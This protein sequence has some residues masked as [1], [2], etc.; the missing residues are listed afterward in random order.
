MN[1]ELPP[2]SSVVALL[3]MQE[4]ILF[5]CDL[6]AEHGVY[7]VNVPV[8]WTG[9]F[10]IDRARAAL[11]RALGRHDAFRIRIAPGHSNPEAGPWGQSLVL[12]PAQHQVTRHPTSGPIDPTSQLPI[13]AS[14]LS[15][16]GHDAQIMITFHHV[17]ADQTSILILIEDFIAF[18]FNDTPAPAGD[19]GAAVRGLIKRHSACPHIEFPSGVS[20]IMT[21][22]PPPDSNRAA[23]VPS[24]VRSTSVLDQPTWRAISATA[25]SHGLSPHLVVVA[26]YAAVLARWG[27]SRHI[28]IGI[29][30]SLRDALAEPRTAGC[31]MTVR[32]LPI[33]V[34]P[35]RSLLD[36]AKTAADAFA[37][38]LDGRWSP[39]L[40]QTADH[41]PKGVVDRNPLFDTILSWTEQTD[42]QRND[43]RV[44]V[45]TPL[46]YP[47]RL[48]FSILADVTGDGLSLAIDWDP[49]KLTEQT[50]SSLLV[51]LEAYLRSTAATPPRPVVAVAV[52][53]RPPRHAAASAAPDI[54]DDIAARFTAA[55][56][57]CAVMEA[58][59]E[60]H[61][62][63]ALQTASARVARWAADLPRS[64][65]IGLA[66]PR[67]FAMVA[68]LIGL[69]RAGRTVAL[70][71]PDDPGGIALAARS[72]DLTCILTGES[73]RLADIRTVAIAD[74][75][76]RGPA[77][78]TIERPHI[79]DRDAAILVFT[80][81]TSGLPKPVLLSRGALSSHAAWARDHFQITQQDRVLQFCSVAFDAM[82]EEIL[83]TLAAGAML[84]LRDDMS[85]ASGAAFA[86]YCDTRR[87]TVVDIPTGFF[88][89][90]IAEMAASAPALPPALLSPGLLPPSL[91]LVVIGGEPYAQAALTAW[92]RLTAGCADHPALLTTYGP[93]ETTIV[94]AAG[95]PTASALFPLLGDARPDCS[96]YVLDHWLEPCPDGVVGE[97]FVGGRA[98]AA[99]YLS[100]ATATA[101]KFIPDP[102]AH[103]PGA[104]MYRTGDMVVRSANGTLRYIGRSDRQIKLRGVRIEPALIETVLSAA[105]DGR[106]V[107][108]V[109]LPSSEAGPQRIVAFIQPASGTNEASALA[110]ARAGLPSMA[111]PA[112]IVFRDLP[113]TRRGKIDRAALQRTA[114]QR[115]NPASI[116]AQATSVNPYLDLVTRCIGQGALS[117][118]DD[119]FAVGGNS[120][121]VLRLI[122]LARDQLGALVDVR[123]VFRA[124]TIGAIAALL[125][126]APRAAPISAAPLK[127]DSRKLSD[128]EIA[129]YLDDEVTRGPSPYILEET[130]TFESRLDEVQLRRA[131][132]TMLAR[133]P[134]L[135]STV[136]MRHGE[137]WWETASL[138]RAI[139]MVLSPER[140]PA[141]TGDGVWVGL[142]IRVDQT[143]RG[144]RIDVVAHH[145][146]LDGAGL[147]R[148]MTELSQLYGSAASASTQHAEERL[149]PASPVDDKL[150]EAWRIRLSGLE[151]LVRLEP[152]REAE[153]ADNSAAISA[154]HSTGL[155]LEQLCGIELAARGPNI[156]LMAIVAAWL[157]RMT[158]S[159]E[160]L[161]FLAS[162][163]DADRNGLRVAT[164]VLPLRS[165]LRPRETFTT[166]AD[167]AADELTW[168]L[169]HR[170]VGLRSTIALLRDQLG[171]HTRMPLLFDVDDRR[172][173][174]ELDFAGIRARRA[175]HDPQTVRADVEITAV[176]NP[177]GSVAFRI[178]ARSA[179][180]TI[181][182]AQAWVRSLCCFARRIAETP[183]LPVGATALIDADDGEAAVRQGADPAIDAPV[184]SQLMDALVLQPDDARIVD[185]HSSWSGRRALAFAATI[186]RRLLALGLGPGAPVYCEMPRSIQY[187]SALLAIWSIGAIPV[188]VNPEHPIARRRSM[189]SRLP[190]AATLA[191][192]HHIVDGVVLHLDQ[193]TIAAEDD[194]IAS[195]AS[196]PAGETA[197]VAFTSGSTGEPKP[198]A[199]TWSGLGHLLSW[200]RR[201]VPM[202]S[203]HSFLHTSAPG[204]DIAVWEMLHPLISGAQLVVAES[205]G[206]GDV[207][208]TVALAERFHCTH[209]HFVP[210]V[211]EAFLDALRPDEGQALELV[212]CGGDAT[213]GS[214]HRRLLEQRRLPMQHCYGPTEATIFSLSWRG[215][216]PSPWLERLP[217]GDPIDGAG[218]AVVD[219]AGAP[220]VRGVFGELAVFGGALA[221]GYLG[222]ATETAARFR[223]LAAG[224]GP[225][226]S[227]TYLTG[228]RVRMLPGGAIEYRGRNDRQIKISGIRVE[229]SEVEAALARA[230]GVT[231]AV[232]IHQRVSGRDRLIAYVVAPG[233]VAED[234]ATI[235]RTVRDAARSRLPAAVVPH[236]VIVLDALPLNLNGKVD[237]SALPEPVIDQE[238][239][240]ER[241]D[242]ATQVLLIALWQRVLGRTS[243]GLDDDFF[244][245]GGDSMTAIRLVAMAR[246]QDLQIRLADVFRNPTVRRLAGSLKTASVPLHSDHR[247]ALGEAARHWL[248]RQ[249]R[250][251]G[252]GIQ[253]MLIRAERGLDA[254]R[255]GRAW[256]EV[257]RR[258]H[259]LSL[260]VV[261]DGDEWS[262]SFAEPWA[263]GRIP[264]AD[265]ADAA[266]SLAIGAVAPST[267]VMAA[268]R[269]VAGQPDLVALA[270]HHLAADWQS[271]STIL[272]DMWEA[273]QN[274]RS[275]GDSTSPAARQWPGE[276]VRISDVGD[277]K[278]SSASARSDLPRRIVRRT[279]SEE[280]AKS[281]VSARERRTALLLASATE[282]VGAVL[283]E[284]PVAIALEVDGRP[285]GDD[286]QRSRSETVGWFARYRQLRVAPSGSA[287]RDWLAAA[288]SALT[289]DAADQTAANC[290]C[291]LNIVPESPPL[292]PAFTAVTLRHFDLEP[293]HPIAIEVELANREDNENAISIIVDCDDQSPAG[294]AEALADAMLASLARLARLERRAR[295]TPLQAAMVAANLRRPDDRFYH[296]QII[297]EIEGNVDLPALR[298]A[299]TWAAQIHDAFRGRF[300]IHCPDGPELIVDPQ[301]RTPWRVVT[302]EAVA[303]ACRAALDD[304]LAEPFDLERGPLSRN[305][306]ATGRDGTRLIW[307]H[308]HSMFDGWSL[309]LV[310]QTVARVYHALRSGAPVRIR[311]PSLLAFNA[312]WDARDLDSSVTFWVERL[313]AAP[314]PRPLV[315][316]APAS[317][318]PGNGRACERLSLNLDMTQ[319]LIAAGNANNATL[320]EM[321]LAAWSLVLARELQTKTVTFGIVT[322]MRPPD[323]PGSADMVGLLMN[324]VP[325][326]IT[327]QSDFAG[328][329]TAARRSLAETLDHA[330]AP[331]D[332]VFR[333][334]HDRG[335]H[336][337]FETL[338][339]FENYPGDRSGAAL[340]GDGR[341]TVLDAHESS[342]TPFVLVALPGDTLQF[343]LLHRSGQHEAAHRLCRQLDRVL[344][345]FAAIAETAS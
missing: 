301:P 242:D 4:A 271:W 260:R 31:L 181:A 71:D 302:A 193:L 262:V 268:L 85:A 139:Q 202:T 279:L 220:V 234:R 321:V 343:E 257:L 305:S 138:D 334:L 174:A 45:G 289:S 178:R 106:P 167:H 69:L 182:A 312:W 21:S 338:L 201:N 135:R 130:W 47:A 149:P 77:S 273:Y 241:P 187:P 284:I 160:V 297:F 293:S 235:I 152:D 228:D 345:K 90:A 287:P 300:D 75:L 162:L 13:R 161:L 177:D 66:V 88:N 272:E 342:E 16:G 7:T 97:L 41:A 46:P 74:I 303:D 1:A 27:R 144:H 143:E 43:I 150:V 171:R 155:D 254:D 290:R 10:D 214:L 48:D 288:E 61:D 147:A 294:T 26:A 263:S 156:E 330:D 328:L 192:S 70:L 140:P 281:V 258:H 277:P 44:S 105:L 98:L 39:L 283:T 52:S 318:E 341:L 245:L 81:G 164:T 128:F 112:D 275:R 92:R 129:T 175:V 53:P 286:A 32:P 304:D 292:P 15:S 237:R 207:T 266:L 25:R 329:L 5:D 121:A 50:A 151:E 117:A 11:Q 215:D 253:A 243:V 306:L 109:T 6:L 28:V 120:L 80:S 158:G 282:A 22:M 86:A 327:I 132:A 261:R 188:L 295:S 340:A 145:A 113:L 136:T 118:A 101:A 276:R 344:T 96:L 325:C 336:N 57:R 126:A 213:P 159:R 23:T 33:E 176:I 172:D 311:A 18:Y 38:L 125:E 19:Y 131:I 94:V 30:V 29:P 227:R 199:C 104:R 153:A 246:K 307:S 233:H 296:T 197:Y 12:Q 219:A 148:F 165:R 291:V 36:V 62:Y 3:P 107:A 316:D 180:Y 67:S 14:I 200:S 24:I 141:R 216:R 205:D 206:G 185:A 114:A 226:G 95:D 170:H 79:A 2:L 270:I 240:T 173:S 183:H 203:G 315:G 211:L 239:Q 269:L 310:V 84:V 169:D 265:G 55:A 102:F 124:R 244:G 217:L 184:L 322:A 72:A 313:T 210:S 232:A 331:I 317:S 134:I 247:R 58:D 222:L 83:P 298:D 99:G 299:W 333:A 56:E 82:L 108:V 238:S 267:G 252:P 309:N 323:I 68:G 320:H 122:A 251:D 9:P 280:A 332:R 229:L 212:L 274:D 339:V 127:H 204:F 60:C 209:V 335:W 54:V 186:A 123:G 278:L 194:S 37:N 236:H 51:A 146:V 73:L 218:I 179:L 189:R 324:T 326:Q 157:H 93:T 191:L 337:R 255:L 224:L 248:A 35:E 17:A 133:H 208:S 89:L 76:D 166:F 64:A 250:L 78:A 249:T 259:A 196:W 190:A 308:H 20:G 87:I 142:W 223:P 256:A 103:V 285:T 40:S 8:R 314:R 137:L 110:R 34:T 49:L 198:V 168:A 100:A 119:F 230:P 65:P 225:P 63:A 59:G 42:I 231:R 111:W 115:A 221:R 195:V 116:E 91:R 319:R 154:S 264:Q 163:S